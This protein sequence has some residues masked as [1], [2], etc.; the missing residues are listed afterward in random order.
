MASA[1]GAGVWGARTQLNL[2]FQYKETDE[3]VVSGPMVS[4][5]LR[6]RFAL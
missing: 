4:L 3:I 2:R 1:G 6:Y 5:G